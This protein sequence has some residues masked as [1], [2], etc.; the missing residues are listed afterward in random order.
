MKHQA[1]VFGKKMPWKEAT[2]ELKQAWKFEKRPGGWV[3]AIQQKPDGSVE[4]IRFSFL[5]VKSQFWAKLPKSSI[6]SSL[7][8]YGDCTAVSRSGAQQDSASDFT[9]QFPGKVRK[10]LVKEGQTVSSDVPLLMIEAMKM[11]FAI[12]SSEPGMVQKILVEEGQVLTPGQKLLLF[13][14]TP[15]AEKDKGAKK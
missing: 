7:D 3:I 2:P 5:Q 15:A 4:R 12:K 10:V 9:A 13:E 8:F 1:K 14:A 11:E 6:T